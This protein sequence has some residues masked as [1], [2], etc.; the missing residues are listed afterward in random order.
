MNK[1]FEQDDLI[2]NKMLEFKHIKALI[3][4]YVGIYPGT[5]FYPLTCA[6]CGNFKNTD[7]VTTVTYCDVNQFKPQLKD[8]VLGFCSKYCF[9]YYRLKVY[10]NDL[11]CTGNS[12]KF[13]KHKT[14]N[15][16][17]VDLLGHS[18]KKVSLMHPIIRQKSL[19]K[20][21]LNEKRDYIVRIQVQNMHVNWN[22]V[23]KVEYT[24][25]DFGSLD[26]FP[27]KRMLFFQNIEK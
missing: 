20:H 25:R 16:W 23:S 10:P 22:R 14:E 18:Q 26:F 8:Y 3:Q 7:W 19:Y 12:I 1:S 2:I 6:N 5:Y 9:N 13:L 17:F 21:C 4:A 27:I 11:N 15:K 24:L